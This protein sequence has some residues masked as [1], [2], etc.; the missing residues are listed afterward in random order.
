MRV[1]DDIWKRAI[2]LHLED[3][4]EEAEEL[5][6]KLLEQNHDNVGLMS[7]YGSLCVQMKKWGLGIHF[8]EASIEKGFK[9]PDVYTNL[10]LAY[11]AVSLVDKA[12]AALEESV[13]DNPT[14]EALVNYSHLFIETSESKKCIEVCERA[15]AMQPDLAMA[16]WNMSIGLLTNGMWDRGWDEYEWGLKTVGMREDRAMLDVP[17]WDGTPGKTV[18][19]YGEQGMGDEIMFASML[20]DLLKTNKVVL[21]THKRLK[22]LFEK[23]F[24]EIKVYGTRE[25]DTAPWVKDEKIDY[26]LAI[27]SLGKFY[28]RTKESFHG[29]PYLKAEAIQKDTKKFRVGISWTGGWIKE[30]RR[31]KRTIPIPWWKPIL[32]RKNVEFVSLQYTDSD[33]DIEMLKG[34]GLEVRKMN[35]YVKADDYYET[36]KLVASCD[37]VISVCTTVI[38]LA[39]ALGVPCWVMTPRYPAWRY[40]NEGPMPWYKSVRLYRAPDPDQLA[41]LPVVDKVAEDLQKLV[42]E[43]VRLRLVG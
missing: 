18:M 13:K 28:R 24:P 29:E 6:I 10:G 34:M 11:R 30:G 23:S 33:E 20:P 35:E 8:L 43:K 39:G 19:V 27:G 22:T 31:L 14:P 5:Y 36:A 21:E 4:F 12:R 38:H 17:Y 9:Q 41:W 1:S 7:T 37:L 40:Q 42:G 26:R 15:V 25:D 16:H 2:E 32:D 3:R